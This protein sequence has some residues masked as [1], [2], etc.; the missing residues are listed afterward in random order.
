MPTS[1]EPL[2]KTTKAAR[3]VAANLSYS[4]DTQQAQAKHLLLE[5][6]NKIDA[7]DIRVSVKKDGLFITDGLGRQ[8]FGTFK[9]LWLYRLFGVIPNAV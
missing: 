8:R 6:A 1:F 9:E 5:M 7:K 4:G 2:N 3:E